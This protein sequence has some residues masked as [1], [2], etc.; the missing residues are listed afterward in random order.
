MAAGRGR[1]S[2]LCSPASVPWDED[3]KAFRLGNGLLAASV[4]SGR[5]TA[6]TPFESWNSLA[7]AADKAFYASKTASGGLNPAD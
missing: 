7:C 2:C 5:F 6:D 1:W 3:S 4:D